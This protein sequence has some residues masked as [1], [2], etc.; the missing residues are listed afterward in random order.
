MHVEFTGRNMEAFRERAVR[1]IPSRHAGDP[2]ELVGAVTCLVGDDS[3]STT[4][5]VLEVVGGK[6]WAP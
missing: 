4:G 3:G 6:A 5:A 1:E 2:A